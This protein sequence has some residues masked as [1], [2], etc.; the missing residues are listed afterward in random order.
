MKMAEGAEISS[1]LANLLGLDVYM[2]TTLSEWCVL[3][4]T[5]AQ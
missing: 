3:C 4:D 2:Y 5:A 1:L